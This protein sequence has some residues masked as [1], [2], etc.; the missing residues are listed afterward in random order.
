M[1]SRELIAKPSVRQMKLLQSLGITLAKEQ[2]KFID[3]KDTRAHFFLSREV[4]QHESAGEDESFR[5]S[6][7]R[8]TG[9]TE[10]QGLRMWSMRIAESFWVRDSDRNIDDGFRASY[11]FE[12]TNSGVV[13]A[14]KKVH[15]RRFEDECECLILIPSSGEPQLPIGENEYDSGS[16]AYSDEDYVGQAEKAEHWAGFWQGIAAYEAVSA[17]DCDELIK[18]IIEF[19]ENSRN[20]IYIPQSEFTKAISETRS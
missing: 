18:D 1:N 11:S 12:W 8:F 7:H 17:A 5:Y 9:R 3:K 13:R 16:A 19:G 20:E 10:K 4:Q 15:A 14:V 2:S 6:T